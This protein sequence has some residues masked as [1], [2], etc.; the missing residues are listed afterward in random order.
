MT[1]PFK[2]PTHVNAVLYSLQR[3]V[4]RESVLILFGNPL[5]LFYSTI[6][7]QSTTK[8]YAFLTYQLA[9]NF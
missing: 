2:I 8:P 4:S 1:H 7:L 6:K 9:F 5:I 3:F